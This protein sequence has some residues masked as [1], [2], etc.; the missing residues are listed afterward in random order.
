MESVIC[1]K[2]A[3][4]K[5]V[6]EAESLLKFLVELVLASG[7]TY[8]L[9]EFLLESI[10]FYKGLLQTLLITGH[11]DILPHDVSELLVN[12]I[13]RLC[14]S[15]SKETVDS[16]LNSLL[17]LNKLRRVDICLRLGKLL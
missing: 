14:S 2:F 5:E 10:D 1:H 9:V 8:S 16:C 15:D 4:F 11:S 17:C 12:G 13:H 7:H 3:N 6:L